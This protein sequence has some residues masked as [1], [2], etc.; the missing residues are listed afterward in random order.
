MCAWLRRD[1]TAAERE[2]R[3][4]NDT[5][6]FP[7]EALVSFSVSGTLM[8]DIRRAAYNKMG[9]REHIHLCSM[10]AVLRMAG[11]ADGDIYTLPGT[12]SK[13]VYTHNL[14][15]P[16]VYRMVKETGKTYVFVLEM[17]ATNNAGDKA[18]VM[19]AIELERSASGH[20]L[21]SAYPLDKLNKIQD[22]KQQ[23]LMVYSKYTD[24]EL[25][26]LINKQATPPTNN[27]PSPFKL[28]LMRLA[29]KGGL[30]VNVQTKADLVKYKL[31]NGLSFSLSGRSMIDAADLGAMAHEEQMQRLMNHARREAARWERTFANGTTNVKAAEAMGTI[32]SIQ[33]AIYKVLPQGYRPELARQM[34]YVEVYARMLETGRVRAYGK[35]KPEELEALNEE[36]GELLEEDLALVSGGIWYDEGGSKSVRYSAFSGCVSEMFG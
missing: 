11:V 4:F 15:H 9:S 36:L 18:N 17:E 5:L 10:P 34:R 1:W 32:S 35:L 14:S 25:N 21:M 12:I 13:L 19:A 7:G 24:A 23:G 33:N 28:D 2:A 3:P 22:I 6:E 8:E 31:A 26:A 16:E 29:V 30:G 27:A 20:Y